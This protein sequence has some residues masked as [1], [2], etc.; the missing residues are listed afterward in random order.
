ME[1]RRINALPPYVFA[2]IDALKMDARRAGQ[3]V[4]DLDFLQREVD[5]ALI[6]VS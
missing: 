3:D 4:V 6:Q 2:T 1:F 5:V